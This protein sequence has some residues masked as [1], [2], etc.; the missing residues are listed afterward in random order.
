MHWLS[1]DA[2]AFATLSL[3][4]GGISTDGEDATLGM[5]LCGCH[6]PHSFCSS[7]W[8]VAFRVYWS[9][10]CWVQV[11]S[12]WCLCGYVGFQIGFLA[13]RGMHGRRSPLSN[14]HPSAEGGTL[15]MVLCVRSLLHI[16]F[17]L[18]N[19]WLHSWCTGHCFV[20]FGF[21]VADICVVTNGV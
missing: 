7:E 21:Q 12:G 10:F 11:P 19:Q 1:I 6:L 14:M 5:L 16:A 8:V 15:G 13:I 9:L 3:H 18:V 4:N 17:V 2:L 20:G